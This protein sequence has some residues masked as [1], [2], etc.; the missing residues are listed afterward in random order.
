MTAHSFTLIVEG[1][2]LQSDELVD[3]V[4]EAGCDDALISRASGIQFADFDREAD[5][6]HD[7][8]LSAIAE[9]K[10]I[11]GITRV[12]LADSGR[13]SM[14]E[15]V[16]ALHQAQSLDELTEYSDVDELKATQ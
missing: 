12:H 6:L 9:L 4:F 8:V 7:A 14:A 2:D 15:T 10:S 5:S 1:P 3:D 11:A 13:E 16:D